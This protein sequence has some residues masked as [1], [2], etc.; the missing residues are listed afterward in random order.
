ME[1]TRLAEIEAFLF[2]P[3]R[4]TL[5]EFGV[6]AMKASIALMKI[7][8]SKGVDTILPSQEIK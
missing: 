1:D 8:K 2:L 3:F 4:G 5:R 6:L 7:L